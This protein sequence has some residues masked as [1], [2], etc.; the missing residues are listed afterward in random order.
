MVNSDEYILSITYPGE[1]REFSDSG[2][3]GYGADCIGGFLRKSILEDKIIRIISLAASIFAGIASLL[4][5]ML[6][7][8]NTAR[9]L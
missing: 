6:M 7:V 3:P 1:S 2:G 9:Y 4:L 5:F 8:Q